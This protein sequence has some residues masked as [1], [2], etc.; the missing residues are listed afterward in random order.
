MVD[1]FAGA[2][3]LGTWIDPVDD[4]RHERRL[5]SAT[6]LRKPTRLFVHRR[7]VIEESARGALLLNQ[8]ELL[9]DW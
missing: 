8:G 4:V 9:R 3:D 1:L 5:D 7:Q 6:L 2:G